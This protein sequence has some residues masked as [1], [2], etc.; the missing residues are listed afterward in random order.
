MTIDDIP[1]A[2]AWA[3]ELKRLESAYNLLARPVAVEVRIPTGSFD[4]VTGRD[5]TSDIVL[6]GMAVADLRKVIKQDYL[7]VAAN[8][9]GLG[10]VVKDLDFTPE[11][12]D[13]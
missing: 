6:H 1:R 4:G 13:K 8:L 7:R 11:R 12:G 2:N 9:A 10:I 3:E 5:Y